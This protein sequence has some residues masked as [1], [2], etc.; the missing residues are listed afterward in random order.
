MEYFLL[1]VTL[2]LFLFGKF[3]FKYWINPLSLYSVI[4]FVMLLFY[5]MKL[6][7]YK[8]LSLETTSFIAI[9]F[10]AFVIGNLI[11]TQNS[12]VNFKESISDRTNDILQYFEEN[13]SFFKYLIITLGLIGLLGALHSWYVLLG[14]YGT[15]PKVLINLAAVYKLRISGEIEGIIPYIEIFSYV[16]IFFAG[17]YS[18]YRGKIS[19]YSLIPLIAIIL[20]GITMVGRA[21]ILFGFVEFL[22]VIIFTRYLLSRI[23]DNRKIASSLWLKLTAVFIVVLFLFSITFIKDFRGNIESFRGET[24]QIRKLKDN[25]FFQPSLYLYL[26]GHLG[27]LDKYLEKDE[28]NV[29]FGENTFQYVYNFISKFNFV[30]R[31]RGYQKA[32][33]VPMWMNTGTFLRELHSDFGLIGVYL[34]NL[35]L[36]ILITYFWQKAIFELNIAYLLPLV[37]LSIIVFFS[38]LMIITRL[39]IF[40]ISFLVILAIQYSIINKIPTLKTEQISVR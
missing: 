1:I 24:V 23:S 14:I 25:S 26:S 34:F 39:A 10:F 35:F 16:S 27:V 28:E 31:P 19:V 17:I 12:K 38:F 36:G 8:E 40:P 5:S 30:E 11:V 6:F 7:H 4:W 33:Y 3:L 22:F 2:S 13:L 18:A 9:N 21:N 29:R 37:Y 15:I 32:Y 20:K